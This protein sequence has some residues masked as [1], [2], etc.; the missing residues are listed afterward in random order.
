M[1]LEIENNT[2]K[3]QNMGLTGLTNLGNTCFLNS[4]L[5][6]LSHCYELNNF[7]E[8]GTYKNKLNKI[9][10]SLILI[11]W[12]KL[13]KL[14]WSE[15]CIISPNGFVKSIQRVAKIKDK[16]IFTGFAQNDLTEFLG[17]VIECFNNSIKREVKMNITGNPESKTDILAKKC[18][19]MMKTMYSTEYSEFIDLFYGIHVSQVKST[20]SNY[21]NVI[22]EPFFNLTI[23]MVKENKPHHI[24]DCFDLYTKK[25]LLDNENQILNEETNTREDAEKSIFFWS[26]PNIMVVT[27]KRFNVSSVSI[28]KNQ[29]FVDFEETLD[30]SK[31][32]IGYNKSSYVYELFGICNHMGG[33]HGGH[34]TSYVKNANNKWYH[35]NDTNV[36]KVKDFDSMKTQSAYCFFYRKKK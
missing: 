12:D 22:P 8:K 1:A 16:D 21:I 26:L 30:L 29:A 9:P 31:Y 19:E 27:L 2:N 7:L 23:P 14:M 25:E 15:N 17:F 10:D 20:S 32:V 6:C 33:V 35:F 4:T 18:F 36:N 13:R 28:R 24:M 3:Y 5:Q 34:Y 11:E